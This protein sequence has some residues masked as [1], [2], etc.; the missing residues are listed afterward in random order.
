MLFGRGRHDMEQRPAD[1]SDVTQLPDR[2]R[3]VSNARERNEP[4]PSPAPYTTAAADTDA[5]STAP[6]A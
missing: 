2:L 5:H 3:A 6:T 4:V 1:L